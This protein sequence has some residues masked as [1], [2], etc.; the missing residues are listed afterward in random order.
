M[1]LHANDKFQVIGVNTDSD[2]EDYAKKA[3]DAEVTWRN[4]WSGSPSGGVP[5]VFGIQA[6]PTVILVDKEGVARWQGNFMSEDG[7]AETLAALLAE[8]R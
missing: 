5:S 3:K 8:T 7:F 6:F 4:V 2:P 1:K